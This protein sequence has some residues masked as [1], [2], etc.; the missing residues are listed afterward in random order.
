MAKRFT[1]TDKWKKPFIRSLE[2]PYKLLWFYILDDCD[3]A[4]IWQADFEV[5]SIRIGFLITEKDMMKHFGEKIQKIGPAKF[6]I[7]DFIF[8][9]YGT[10]NDKNRLHLSVIQLLEK[11][12]IKPL[13]SPLEGA[14]Y[15]D[16]DKEQ[17]KDKD[18][19]KEKDSFGKSENLLLI[20]EM[21]RI[22]KANNSTYLGSIERDYKPLYS[23]A[24]FFCEVGKLSGSPDL[25]RDKI[26]EVWEPI[27]KA[28]SKDDFYK[29]KTLSTISNQIQSITQMT[30]HGKSNSKNGKQ[31]Y[32]S[33]E[34]ATE[35]DRLF[36][37]R[38]G[39]GGSANG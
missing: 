11:N 30:L 1:D 27:T 39:S 7:P 2:A 20:P 14:K 9:Q 6:F 16:K 8:F 26:L 19:D 38:Y 32:G 21:F 22:F 13:G 28:I 18:K 4:G 36:A 31:N 37:E 24:S 34:R 29:Q 17:D 3:H 10:L 25:H 5:A 12:K 15:K 35:L 23:I 33:K